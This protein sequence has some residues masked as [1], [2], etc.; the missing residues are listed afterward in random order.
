MKGYGDCSNGSTKR[1]DD[2]W[3]IYLAVYFKT[4]GAEFAL[5]LMAVFSTYLEIGTLLSAWPQA[6]ITQI[7]KKGSKHGTVNYH[8]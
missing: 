3:L 8:Q 2:D 5:T 4:L 6:N 7:Y 1:K